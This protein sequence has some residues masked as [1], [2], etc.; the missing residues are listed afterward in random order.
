MAKTKKNIQKPRQELDGVYLLKMLLYLLLGSMWVKISHGG[1]LHIP[2][3]IGLIVGLVF[4]A[5]EHFQIDRKIE[6]AILL[7]AM[8][9]GYFAPYGLYISF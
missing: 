4:T 1:N 7:V 6:Y 2:I 5:H 8:L 9:F 3:P